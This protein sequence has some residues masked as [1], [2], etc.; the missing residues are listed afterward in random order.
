MSELDAVVEGYLAYLRD[1]GRKAPG[2]L[3]DVRCTFNRARPI[4][5]SIRPGVA[6]WKH[7]FE[8][9]LLWLERLR[10]AGRTAAC[11]NK[12]LSHMRGLLE[13]AWRSGR[14]G[15]NVLDGFSLNDSLECREPR[16]LSLEEARRLVLACPDA[17][18]RERR[19]RLMVLLLYGCG[20]RT[21]EL[22][23]LDVADI[24]RERREITI[25]KAKHD[26]PRIVPIPGGVFVELLAYLLER[27]KRGALFRTEARRRRVCAGDV[28]DVVR[29]AARRAGLEPDVTPKALRHSFA[30]HLMDR[31]VDLAVISSLMGHRS[32]RETGVYLHALP[33]KRE[34]AV[35]KLKL[36]G[37][38]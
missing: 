34:A 8:D 14:T 16:S 2:T 4:M 33:G 37:D 24:D 31:G 20:L 29:S 32:P 1:V 35:Q 25:H 21:G 28:G 17:T 7:A 10:E 30:T 5:E 3:R 6:M 23:A 18:T 11:L 27:G 9:Y 13:Y 19:E 12:Y 36:G 15:R 38:R 22:C 26:R